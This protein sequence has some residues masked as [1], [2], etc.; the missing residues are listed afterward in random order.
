MSEDKP[1]EDTELK[2]T[3]ANV[4]DVL[5]KF[6]RSIHTI[7]NSVYFN[8]QKFRALTM[9]EVRHLVSRLGEKF[10][11]ISEPLPPSYK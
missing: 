9:R 4:R 7:N 11:E 8:D 6:V 5:I 1:Q 3:A 2:L 10:P